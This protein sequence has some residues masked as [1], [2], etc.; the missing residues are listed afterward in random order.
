MLK[1]RKK[2]KKQELKED[3]L[4]LTYYKAREF[5][6]KNKKILSYILTGVIIIVAG[7]IIYRNNVKAE[8]ERA[9]ALL[10]KI[11][12]YYDNGDYKTAIDG[13]PQRNIQGLK[14]IVENYG[15]TDAGEIA[16][17]YLASAYF[18]LGDYDNALKYFK[19]YDG[20][21]KLLFSAS[22]AGIASIYEIKGE[23]KKAGEY[24]EKAAQ[25]FRENILVPE[26]LYNAARNY[27]LAGER[28]KALRLYERIKKD[29]PNFAKIRDVEI[30]IASLKD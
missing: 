30:Y 3:K 9:E 5:V 15:G 24:F 2:L 8:N 11:I 13:I 19:K 4:V 14:Y 10:S 23:Y 7:I 29:Y 26:Y 1:P 18:M 27:K 20:N 25:R 16:T 17:Y 12:G 28:E 21:D 6:E 22:L